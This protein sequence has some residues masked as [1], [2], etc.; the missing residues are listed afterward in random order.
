MLATLVGE[1]FHDPGWIYEEKYDGYRILA[2]KEGNRLELLSRNRNNRTER[3]ARIAAAIRNLRHTNLLLDGEVVVFDRKGVSKFQ[4]LQGG[5]KDSVYVAFDCLYLEG[6]DLREEPLSK[7]R[8]AMEDAIGSSQILKPSRILSPDGKE[9]YELAREKG[10]EG[11]VAKDFS[12]RYVE[13]RSRSWLKIKVHQA[14]E[15][16]IVGY[17]A[18]GGTR[19]NFGALLLGAY[20]NGELHY[21]GKVG[22]GFDRQRL[23]A[24]YEKL[25]P[26]VRKHLELRNPPHG[27][28]ITFVAPKLV[29]QISYQEWTAD[30]KLRQPVFLGL[31]DDKSPR[32]VKL[33]ERS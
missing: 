11:V 33:P 8:A 19:K 30:N 18:P 26:L 24:V 28:G 10:Y 1:P 5:A 9:A 3:F 2:Y 25:Q 32:E 12:S 22:S 13:G 21:A 20:R 15:F 7:R 14:D 23:S 29:A 4:L 17:T 16:V 6:H 31:R 27:A